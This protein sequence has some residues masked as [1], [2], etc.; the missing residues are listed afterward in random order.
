MRGGGRGGGRQKNFTVPAMDV[1]QLLPSMHE[2]LDSTP[3]A[4]KLDLVGH[5]Y[6]A[7]TPEMEARG[8]RV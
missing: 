5:V 6:T 8:V 4:H 7:K 1:T 3:T 2:T